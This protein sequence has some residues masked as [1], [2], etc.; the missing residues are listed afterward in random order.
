MKKLLT[1]VEENKSVLRSGCF[2]RTR[3]QQG[4]MEIPQ[5]LAR[6]I[7]YYYELLEDIDKHIARLQTKKSCRL[8]VMTCVPWDKKINALQGVQKILKESTPPSD[9]IGALSRLSKLGVNKMGESQRLLSRAVRLQK[10]FMTP[11]ELEKF[12]EAEYSRELRQN[13]GVMF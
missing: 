7:C 8:S 6:K 2:G 3:A 11:G 13:L 5:N 4:K 1:P 9:K 10:N 12:Y